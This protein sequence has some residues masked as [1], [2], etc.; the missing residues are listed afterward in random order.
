[1]VGP[2]PALVAEPEPES[3]DV[4]DAAGF[5]EM[6][7]SLDVVGVDSGRG[8][9][10]V[11]RHRSIIGRGRGTCQETRIRRHRRRVAVGISSHRSAAERC[12]DGRVMAE[13]WPDAGHLE[14]PL[15]LFAPA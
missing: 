10:C 9:R 2:F 8:D 1:L 7:E 6:L 5:G 12:L 4:L 13:Q 11:V 3:A 15:D 14:Y